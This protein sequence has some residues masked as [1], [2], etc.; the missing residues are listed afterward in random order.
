M[1][2]D[3][4]SREENRVLKKQLGG[5]R[6]RLNEKLAP[7][8]GGQGQTTGR[9]VLAEIATIITPETL[10]AWHRKLITH[11]YDGT[12]SADRG[13]LPLPKRSRL[14]WLACQ[15]RIGAGATSAYPASSLV[16]VTE[17]RHSYFQQRRP[18]HY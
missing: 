3:A 11:K 4:E 5:R 6:P 14:W 8:S 9:R 16:S 15:K 1:F 10:L 12:P 2:E 7:T 18:V 17:S 13:D